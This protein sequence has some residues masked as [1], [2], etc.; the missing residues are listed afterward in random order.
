MSDNFK[1][2]SKDVK[3]NFNK[4]GGYFQTVLDLGY[5]EWNSD[6]ENV[7]DYDEMIEW[8]RENYGDFAAMVVL[9]GKYNHQVCNGGHLQYWDNGYASNGGGCFTNHGE[10]I[11]LHDKMV[12]WMKTYKLDIAT[13]LTTKVYEIMKEFKVE[14]DDEEYTEE[15][16]FECGGSGEM[17]DYDDPE[18]DE[19]IACS[20]CEGF[21]S[22]DERN[23]NYGQPYSN[24]DSLDTRYYEV[25]EKWEKYMEKFI[26]HA[27]ENR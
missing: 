14:I 19:Y 26:K 9:V 15:T 24:W 21:G 2:L 10:D 13:E 7:K 1:K 17:A 4:E 22:T 23:E 3:D 27:V 11:Y 12:E 20:E 25:N 6:N 18:N 8:M 5:A 16:C